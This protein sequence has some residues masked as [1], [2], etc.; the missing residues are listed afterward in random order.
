[1][2]FLQAIALGVVQGIT[3]FLPVSSSGHLI[4]FPHFFG[5]N[6]QAYD[7]DVIIHVATLL[8]ILWVMRDDIMLIV[9][10]FVT[11]KDRR[12]AWMIL[13][14]TLPVA[15][16]GFLISGDFLDSIRTVQIVAWNLIVWGVVLALADYYSSKQVH[17]TENIKK[18][19]WKQA[20]VI[21]LAQALALIPG[22]SRSG[23]TMTAALFTGQ[24]REVSAR[25][26]FLLA[27]PAI[28]GAGILVSLDT[29]EAGGFSTSFPI[30]ISGFIA[31]FFAGILAIRFLLD[32]LQ[33]A[34]FQ[35]F[36]AYRIV[37]GI[38]LLVFLVN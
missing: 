4:A 26:S 24:S 17:Q 18:T 20:F 32:F 1:M 34:S 37:L 28:A 12:L 7:F 21:G 33:K 35:C 23:I 16:A 36:A 25:Y 15:A 38:I 30:L 10:N 14:G 19:T 27:I 3:E 22:T 11:G 5:W 8:A 29:I 31:A 6:Q 2:S 13:L 9:R